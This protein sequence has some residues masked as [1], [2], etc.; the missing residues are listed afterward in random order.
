MMAAEA[1][2]T[3]TGAAIAPPGGLEL[4]EV[5]EPVGQRCRVAPTTATVSTPSS[6][7]PMRREPVEIVGA[8]ERRPRSRRHLHPGPA[9]DVADLLRSVEVDDGHHHRPEEGGGVEGDGRLD[10]VRQLERDR[11]ARTD[12]PVGQGPGQPPGADV[13]TRR[14][15][16][17]RAASSE[18]IRNVWSA[19]SRSASSSRLPSVRSSQRP[20]AS[21]R[22][23]RS[24]R[25]SAQGPPRSVGRRPSVV[26]ARRSAPGSAVVDARLRCH[27]ARRSPAAR[28]AVRRGRR[29]AT[30]ASRSAMAPTARRAAPGPGRRRRRRRR[31]R[32]TR[33]RPGWRA[34]WAP[35]SRG[36]GRGRPAS[37]SKVPAH[38]DHGDAPS[39]CRVPGLRPPCPRT[40]NT[41]MIWPTGAADGGEPPWSTRDTWSGP[42]TGSTSWPGATG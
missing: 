36:T 13:A 7:S 27:H 20:S 18:W 25:H 1:G 12:P 14:T 11:V 41:T 33:S 39:F 40:L 38:D 30:W 8:P 24:A 28:P 31:S 26:T 17:S 10:P 34:T 9:K 2:S 5:D 15:C 4:V 29:A 35:W 32:C 6:A 22:C 16:P 42:T 21:Q 3:A 23:S 19:W 37:T